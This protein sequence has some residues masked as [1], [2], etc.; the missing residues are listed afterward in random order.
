[1]SSLQS[2]IQA[3]DLNKTK[4]RRPF[5]FRNPQIQTLPKIWFTEFGGGREMTVDLYVAERGDVLK[6][7]KNKTL[8]SSNSFIKTRI[9]IGERKGSLAGWHVD[10]KRVVGSAHLQHPLGDDLAHGRW[11]VCLHT[12][13]VG[14]SRCEPFFRHKQIF[15]HSI[16]FQKCWV[17]VSPALSL[18]IFATKQIHLG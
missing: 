13:K 14:T 7:A 10:R 17:R 1:M 8:I 3:G 6:I 16:V 9:A 2:D 12:L 11:N 15:Q 4:Q 5:K 18:R